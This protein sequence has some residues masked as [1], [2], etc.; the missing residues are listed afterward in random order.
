MTQ[1]QSSVLAD[2]EWRGLIKQ[3][4]HAEALDQALLDGP[5]TLY[6]G[7]DPTA[8]SLH[9]GSLL[10]LII[11]ARFRR[12][13]HTPI[14]L[15]GG[16][17]GM[18]GDPSGKN[19][20][21]N[22]LGEDELEHNLAGLRAQ[23]EAVLNR[24][25]TMHADHVADG[26]EQ[27]EAEI[28]NNADWMKGFGYLEFLRDVGKSFKVNQMVKKDSVRTRMESR[29]QGISYT[30]FSYMLL[31]A[32]DFLHLRQERGCKLQVGGSDQ[33]GNITAGTDLIGTRGVGDAFGLT[34]PLLTKS[35]GSKF[36]KSE[37]GNV[38]LDPARTSSFKFYQFWL[39]ET[40]DDDATSFLKWFTF[41]SEDEIQALED[42]PRPNTRQRKLAW[43]VTALVHGP[44]AADHAV[45][46]SQMLFKAEIKDLT[47]A[48]LREIFA[49]VPSSQI[50]RS[51]LEGEGESLVALLVETGLQPS[52]GAA[53]RLLK[54]NGASINNRKVTEGQATRVTL[55]DLASESMLVL[56]SGKKS[57]HVIELVH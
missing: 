20:E 52:N 54:Q 22:M 43:E 32:Y 45:H 53:R 14:A 17:T 9:A 19:S 13:G 35:D 31:Q 26:V 10:P 46:A 28:V 15:V 1:F 40:T 42:D 3:Q 44:E 5:L 51:R 7:F 50:E 21:R 36:G 18:I 38:W 24:A 23:I 12:H 56:K 48:E 30:E 2:L 25:I 55:E 49:D 41:L 8:D 57:L 29:D 33:W 4:T 39:S 11:L 37:G 6:C 47:D 34:F 16:A 27:G